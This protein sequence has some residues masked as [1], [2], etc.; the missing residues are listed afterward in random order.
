MFGYFLH[1]KKIPL[2]CADAQFSRTFLDALKIM[3]GRHK[4]GLLRIIIYRW[5]SNII[6]W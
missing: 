6:S 1:V 2:H 3:K 5:Y 4:D